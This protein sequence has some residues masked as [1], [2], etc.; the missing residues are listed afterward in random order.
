MFVQP[1]DDAFN[2]GVDLIL[3]RTY[4]P[5]IYI[6]QVKTKLSEK[7][8]RP[9]RIFVNFQISGMISVY[10]ITLFRLGKNA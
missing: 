10:T 9:H 6:K 2:F 1:H 3:T 4:G 5:Q 7:W 8:Q